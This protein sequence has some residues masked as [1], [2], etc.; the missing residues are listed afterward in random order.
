MTTLSAS[1]KQAASV[2]D[3][4]L[5]LAITRRCSTLQNRHIPDIDRL[6]DDHLNKDLIIEDSDARIL[7]YF[8]IAPEIPRLEI[9]RLVIAKREMICAHNY[10]LAQ[11]LKKGD[12]TRSQ[13]KTSSTGQ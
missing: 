7:S 2:T 13:V 12:K 9:N 3:E 1:S 8:Y 5:G 6:F 10:M 4:D 11:E